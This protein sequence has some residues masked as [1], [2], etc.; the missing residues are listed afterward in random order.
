VRLGVGPFDDDGVL[1][2]GTVRIVVRPGSG[3]VGCL[4]RASHKNPF[5]E[6]TAVSGRRQE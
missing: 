3:L 1:D 2:L 5:G 6:T 4:S